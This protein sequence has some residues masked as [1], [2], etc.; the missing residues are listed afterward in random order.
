MQE[1]GMTRREKFMENIYYIQP[2]M[3][4]T[5]TVGALNQVFPKVIRNWWPFVYASLHNLC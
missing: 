2:Y 4:Q 5:L 3:L 1:Q